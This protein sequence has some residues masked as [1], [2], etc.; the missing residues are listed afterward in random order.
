M[1]LVLQPAALFSGFILQ[2]HSDGE[3]K[4]AIWT[5]RAL[6]T[7]SCAFCRRHRR[8]RRGH[9]V[10]VKTQRL[11]PQWFHLRVCELMNCHC[12]VLFPTACELRLLP[13]RMPWWQGWTVCNSEVCELNFLD[14]KFKNKFWQGK[15][16]RKKGSQ[17]K[18]MPRAKD[19]TK[20][21]KKEDVK[22]QDVKRKG[23][24]EEN[25]P[26]ERDA[27]RKLWKKKTAVTEMRPYCLFNTEVV[28]RTSYRHFLPWV[29]TGTCTSCIDWCMPVCVCMVRVCVGACV[30]AWVRGC[31]AAWL[32]GC[33]AACMRAC[34]CV[35]VG[36]W[37]CVCVW[38]VWI[39]VK[40][41]FLFWGL[42]A[43][44]HC[45]WLP[46]EEGCTH[47]WYDSGTLE[48]RTCDFHFLKFDRVA[49]G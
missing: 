44:G 46:N 28:F 32:R 33:V 8:D 2:K 25:L 14:V 20:R 42:S 47:D 6:A 38:N 27:K 1:K 17:Q 3:V 30:G 7:V 9:H 4:R 10:P 22:E 21:N 11:A 34:V 37:V 31:V 29:L 45:S 13:R 19:H 18:E 41:L 49:R 5:N 12:D 36:G 40:L 16:E 43:G 23:C 35:W 48:S 39:D 26:R 15:G 24:Q